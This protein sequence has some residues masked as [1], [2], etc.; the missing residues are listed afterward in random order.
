MKQFGWQKAVPLWG[1]AQSPKPT[2]GTVFSTAQNF[3]SNGGVFGIG[4]DSNINISLTE[5]LRLLEYSQ[6]LQHQQR[7]VLAPEGGHTGDTLYRTAARGGAQALSRKAGS[8]AK[9][10]LA[11]LVAIDSTN[12]ALCALNDAQLLDG[13]VFAANDTVVTDLWSAGRHQ[14]QSGRHVRQDEIVSGFQDA[15]ADLKSRLAQA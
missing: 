9:G 3:L 14:V 7:N 13:F 10:M 11:D 12:P 5:E 6:R 4:S 2:L 8:I 15:M 1:C